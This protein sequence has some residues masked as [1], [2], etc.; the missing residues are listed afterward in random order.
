MCQPFITLPLSLTGLV[1]QNVHDFYTAIRGPCQAGFEFG[2]ERKS[3]QLTGVASRDKQV[4]DGI[5][6]LKSAKG[7]ARTTIA[8]RNGFAPRS[9]LREFLRNPYRPENVF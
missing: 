2:H 9:V 4:R 6:C 8:V 7:A 3:S 1:L 5:G